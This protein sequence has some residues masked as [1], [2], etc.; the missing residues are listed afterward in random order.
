MVP[1]GGHCRQVMKQLHPGYMRDSDD[2]A[3]AP[4]LSK[5]FGL[6]QQKSKCSFS[7]I[8]IPSPAVR[9]E[10]MTSLLMSVFLNHSTISSYASPYF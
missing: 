5:V 7:R 3:N 1:K 2:A 4:Q 10:L 6:D 8:R 9:I